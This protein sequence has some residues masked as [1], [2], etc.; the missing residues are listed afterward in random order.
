L[1]ITQITADITFRYPGFRKLKKWL[2]HIIGNEGF[3]TGEISIVFCSDRY[4]RDVNMKFLGRDYYTDVITFDYSS[5]N[6]IS[7]DVMISIERV[8][9]NSADLNTEFIDELDRVI[10]HGIL[11]IAGYNDSSTTE[12]EKMRETE[13]HYLALRKR[14]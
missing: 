6:R 13:D 10:C 7:G 11:H 14:I 1:A 4:L 12:Q 2:L 9:E 5:G 8:T 3:I